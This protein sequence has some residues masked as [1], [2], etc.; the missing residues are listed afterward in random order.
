MK[1]AINTKGT[2]IVAG[3]PGVG[4]TWCVNNIGKYKMLDSD[5]SEFSWLY[6]EKKEKTDVRNPDF[7]ENY[8]HHILENLGKY[9]IIFVSSH[10]VVRR[11]LENNSIPYVLVFPE[12]TKDNKLHYISGYMKRGSSEAFC[13]LIYD[14]WTNWIE[15]MKMETWPVQYILGSEDEPTKQ[16]L[17][18]VLDDIVDVNK[19]YTDVKE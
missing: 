12:D 7:P 4:K 1:Q 17:Y 15:E 13:S 11:A 3:F 5:S 9:D 2:V 16:N 14:N 18:A 6:N 10:D 19:D 8:I